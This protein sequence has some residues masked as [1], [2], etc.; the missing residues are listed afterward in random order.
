[1]VDFNDFNNKQFDEQQIESKLKDYQEILNT[2]DKFRN[3]IQVFN[4]IVVLRSLMKNETHFND[5]I[6]KL[7]EYQNVKNILT[8]NQIKQV[9]LNKIAFLLLKNKVSE[10]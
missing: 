1:M 4:N 6:K 8:D 7:E 3:K 5:S 9:R 10:S 2:N